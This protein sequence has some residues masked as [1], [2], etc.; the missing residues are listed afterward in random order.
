MIVPP[1]RKQ[2]LLERIL[3]EQHNDIAENARYYLNASLP[4]A[5]MKEIAWAEMT[6][7]ESKL[8]LKKREAYLEGF[9]DFYQEDVLAPY[10][11]KYFK[12]LHEQYHN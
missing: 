11:D 6:N 10:K 5:A 9:M 8:P 1:E 4:D 12:E 2:F 3:G 7:K